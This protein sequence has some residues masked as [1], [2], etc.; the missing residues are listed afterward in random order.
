VRKNGLGFSRDNVTVK[1]QRR[2]VNTKVN[3]F[4]NAITNNI[5]VH[6]TKPDVNFT[7]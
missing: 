2:A 5:F 1:R 3:Q 6:L 4:V 7:S